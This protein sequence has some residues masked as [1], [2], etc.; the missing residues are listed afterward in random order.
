[1][2]E[3]YLGISVSI[4]AILQFALA[5]FQ[6]ILMK[7]QTDMQKQGIKIALLDKRMACF[8]VVNEARAQFINC[9]DAAPS[10]LRARLRCSS[11]E[12]LIQFLDSLSY[13]FFKAALDAEYLFSPEISNKLKQISALIGQYNMESKRVSLIQKKINDDAAAGNNAALQIVQRVTQKAAEIERGGQV[14][15]RELMILYGFKEN[16]PY[17]VLAEAL[18][19][20]FSDDGFFNVFLPYL[21]VNDLG[22]C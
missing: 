16:C 12:Q 13:R 20:E 6:W 14:S 19:K 7:K 3:K 15:E 11:Q 8:S 21:N 9:T 10:Y 18:K 22:S 5:V 2:W 4:V 17:W 1:M